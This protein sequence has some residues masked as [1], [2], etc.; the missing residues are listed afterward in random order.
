[1]SA[2]GL[3]ELSRSLLVVTH[4]DRLS[5]AVTTEDADQSVDELNYA[6]DVTQVISYLLALRG[7]V[8]GSRN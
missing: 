1:M 5:V 8:I 2:S 7:L 4:R 3:G 6:S